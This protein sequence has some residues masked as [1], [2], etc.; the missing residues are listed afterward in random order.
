M[1][2]HIWNLNKDFYKTPKIIQVAKNI[3]ISKTIE[4]I[5]MEFQ[6]IQLESTSFW[7][8]Y[9]LTK[10]LLGYRQGRYR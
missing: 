5:L 1:H 10:Y 9:L 8:V 3:T 7:N 6:H 2:T 4:E